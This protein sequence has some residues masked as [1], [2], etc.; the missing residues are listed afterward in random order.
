VDDA[1]ADG[2]SVADAIHRDG[3]VAG[4]AAAVAERAP[5]PTLDRAV[6]H[7]RTLSAA[8]RSTSGYF[9]QDDNSGLKL[10]FYSVATTVAVARRKA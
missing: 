7:R 10:R 2:D 6:A 9:W 4:R 5:A 3:R 1:G 8:T